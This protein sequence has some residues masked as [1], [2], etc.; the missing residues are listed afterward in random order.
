MGTMHSTATIVLQNNNVP[1]PSSAPEDNEGESISPAGAHQRRT[2]SHCRRSIAPSPRM[3][4]Q[5]YVSGSRPT[6]PLLSSVPAAA[7]DD[8]PGPNLDMLWLLLRSDE[9][10]SQLGRI[11][12]DTQTAPG[13]SGFNARVKCSDAP[14]PTTVGYLPLI[15]EPP[16]N[17]SAVQEVI[18]R[19]INISRSL[20]QQH[21]ILTANQAVYA[22]AVEIM[23][24]KRAKYPELVIRMGAFHT[25]CTF[26]AVIGKRFGYAGLS[27]LLVESG[28]LGQNSCK[29][30]LGGKHYN[31]AVR[32]HKLLYEVVWHKLWQVFEQTLTT[33]QEADDLQVRQ[34]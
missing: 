22:K 17:P 28:I 19:C 1:Q 5:Q 16:S 3:P 6:P 4:L 32:M 8:D 7:P 9:S 24:H 23:W 25:V 11:I 33:G 31:R 18:A 29:A 15:P 30:V 34:P 2:P 20:G 12:G 14:V 27:D 26:L 13:W 21:C 10:V